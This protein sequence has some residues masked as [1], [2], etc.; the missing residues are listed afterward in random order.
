MPEA[1]SLPDL[2]TA[3]DRQLGLKLESR[4]GPVDTY[5]IE[6]VERPSEN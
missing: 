6:R 4:K 1:D 5:V 2:A 3:L